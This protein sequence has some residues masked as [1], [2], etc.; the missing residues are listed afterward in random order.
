[1]KEQAKKKKVGINT[2]HRHNRN[3]I[4]W[5]GPGM[6][7]RP[8]DV[9]ERGWEGE[10]IRARAN[11]REHGSPEEALFKDGTYSSTKDA[12]RTDNR[13]DPPHPRRNFVDRG[14]NQRQPFSR[15]LPKL[16]GRIC[17]VYLTAQN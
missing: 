6:V 12:R 17:G 5:R 3:K 4:P 1:M 11:F 15:E 14:P 13:L 8:T 9:L 10:I 16:T 7:P 2:P